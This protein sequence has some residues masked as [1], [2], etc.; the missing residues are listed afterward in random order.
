MAMRLSQH[1]CGRILLHIVALVADGH[2]RW[3]CAGIAREMWR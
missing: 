1:S 3:H 2:I